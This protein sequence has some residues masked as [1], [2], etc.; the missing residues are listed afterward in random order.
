MEHNKEIAFN[1]IGFLHCH[2]LTIREDEGQLHVSPSHLITPYARD[3]ITRRKPE[4]ID[5]FQL[6]REVNDHQLTA[7]KKEN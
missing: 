4:I 5:V 6:L 7:S 2:G 1:W 3:L